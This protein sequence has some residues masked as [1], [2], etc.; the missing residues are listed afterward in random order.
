MFNLLDL[1]VMSVGF[2]ECC[3]FGYF[4]NEKIP[5]YEYIIFED[6]LLAAEKLLK[7]INDA[8]R[9]DYDNTAE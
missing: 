3:P 5:S 6:K 9:E 4:Y 7:P 1:S 2:S 8:L